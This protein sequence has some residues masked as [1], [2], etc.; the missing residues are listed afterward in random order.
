M[1]RRPFLLALVLLAVGCARQDAPQDA[2]PLAEPFTP[3]YDAAVAAGNWIRGTAPAPD[4]IWPED[5]LAPGE[6][7]IGLASGI[8]G[9]TLFFTE[10]YRVD[11]KA[12]WLSEARR[13]CDRLIAA[14]PDTLSA[15]DLASPRA[16]AALYGGWAGAGFVLHHASVVLPDSLYGVAAHR[17]VDLLV[18]AARP[19]GQGV[20]WND[21]SDIL[22][23]SAGTGSFLLYAAREMGREDALAVARA[24]GVTLLG[25]AERVDGGLTWPRRVGATEILPGFSHGAAGVGYFLA[26]VARDGED[27]LF[28]IAADNTARYLESIAVI[29]SATGAYRLPYGF[30]NPDWQGKSATGWAHGQAGVARFWFRLAELTGDPQWTERV[31]DCASTLREFSGLPG[32]LDPVYM[33]SGTYL[34]RRFGRASVAAFLLDLYELFGVEENLAFARGLVDGLMSEGLRDDAGLRWEFARYA[35]FENPGTPA[36]FTGY[37]YGAAGQGLLLLQLDAAL[38]NEPWELDLPDDSM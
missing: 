33:E 22:T 16:A 11:G 30:G 3:Y 15:E 8:A 37:F 35:F 4:G 23:G 17:V 1:L 21:A 34:D 14:L 10:L 7:G 32:H 36:A 6:P 38:R 19:D 24:A 12:E 13:G 5:A 26:T 28:G 18:A 2:A 31:D 20:S 27:E 29:D 9:T 25:R